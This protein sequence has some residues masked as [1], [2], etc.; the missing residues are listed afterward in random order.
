[1]FSQPFQEESC[2]FFLVLSGKFDRSNEK[3]CTFDS[4]IAFINYGLDFHFLIILELLCVFVINLLSIW[5]M[6]AFDKLI[7]SVDLFPGRGFLFMLGVGIS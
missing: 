3:D 5:W 6:C 7:Y 2:R 4:D 1:M